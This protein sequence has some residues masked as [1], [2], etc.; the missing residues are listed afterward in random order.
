MWLL[1]I[2]LHC[3]QGESQIWMMQQKDWC[4]H[5]LSLEFSSEQQLLR[6][7]H[8]DQHHRKCKSNLVSH[9]SKFSWPRLCLIFSI[10][11]WHLSKSRS[12]QLQQNIHHSQNT[13]WLC[14][15]QRPNQSLFHHE[16]IQKVHWQCLWS[17]SPSTTPHGCFAAVHQHP[18]GPM[19]QSH[20]QSFQ[21][22]PRTSKPW[23]ESSSITSLKQK[24][25]PLIQLALRFW[26]YIY[27]YIYI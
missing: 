24:E 21:W 7:R 4:L 15:S 19:W 5:S 3:P 20:H 23:N 26:N 12:W 17:P 27:I 25:K 11:H 9:H 22:Q 10:L 14:Q 6:L 2:H 16:V 13:R 1:L 8:G 18:C